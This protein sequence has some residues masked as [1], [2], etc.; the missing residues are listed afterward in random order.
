MARLQAR[1]GLIQCT[2]RPRSQTQMAGSAP[3]D[4]RKFF[5]ART[6]RNAPALAQTPFGPH[7]SSDVSKE[8]NVIVP[9]FAGSQQLP[10]CAGATPCAY[11]SK[12]KKWT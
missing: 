12:Q 4:G 1:C 3:F 8:A 9:A 11:T 10:E 5:G 2:H 7:R 6:T